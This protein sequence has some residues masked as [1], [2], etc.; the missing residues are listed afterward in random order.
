MALS[1]IT[2]RTKAERLYHAYGRLMYKTAFDIL[3]GEASDMAD[4][5]I[6]AG[7]SKPFEDIGFSERRKKKMRALF[8]R[9]HR[10]EFHKN[11]PGAKRAAA[12]DIRLLKRY[13]RG[14]MP[15]SLLK[16]RSSVLTER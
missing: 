9:E 5:E 8:K 2:G 14:V 3:I 4:S 15:S 10:R 16:C 11:H 1:R 13:S 7:L 6:G 12:D